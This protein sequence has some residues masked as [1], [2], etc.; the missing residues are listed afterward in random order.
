MNL[1]GFTA[2]ASFNRSSYQRYKSSSKHMKYSSL[3]LI[4]PAWIM[5]DGACTYHCDI[6]GGRIRCVAI[7]C[8]AQVS[9]EFRW[10]DQKISNLD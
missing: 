5:D 3:D 4:S 9:K 6:V 7:M 8:A 2:E 10:Y 1:P